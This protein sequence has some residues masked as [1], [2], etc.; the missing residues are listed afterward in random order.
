MF[1]TRKGIYHQANTDPAPVVPPESAPVQPPAPSAKK[2]DPP[3]EPVEHMIPKTRLDEEIA[4]R[5]KAEKAL[6]KFQEAED[7]RKKDE[8]S[9]VERV[10]LEKTESDQ[11][12]EKAE[13]ALTDERIKNAVYAEAN[14]AQF[15]EKKVKFVS[16]EVAYKL[17]DLSTIEIADGKVKGIDTALKALAKDNP[18]LLEQADNGDRVGSP[19]RNGQRQNQSD[20][21]PEYNLPRI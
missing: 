16:A 1:I 5:D 15:G 2:D 4:K 21:K 6:A 12:A 10:K 7:K 3:A 17:L 14:K 11:R 13:K 8:L 18:F 19:R 20:A 9:E